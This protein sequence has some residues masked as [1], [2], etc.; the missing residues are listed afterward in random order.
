[1]DFARKIARL[2]SRLDARVFRPAM[3]MFTG[4]DAV[5]RFRCAGLSTALMLNWTYSP[6]KLFLFRRPSEKPDTFRKKSLTSDG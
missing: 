2:F 5:L 4:S 6:I 3:A 1:M